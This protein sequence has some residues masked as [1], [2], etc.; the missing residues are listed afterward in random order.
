MIRRL[1]LLGEITVEVESTS[2][3]SQLGEA[4]D[5]EQLGIVRNLVGAVDG[6]ESGNRDVRQLGVV[7]KDQTTHSCEVGGCERLHGV[8]IEAEIIGDI[9]KGWKIDRAAVT[10]RHVRGSLKH[11]ERCCET[12]LEAIVCFNVQRSFD[13][14]DL[15]ANVLQRRVIVDIEARDRVQVVDTLKRTETSVCYQNARG[16]SETSGTKRQ[17]L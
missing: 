17:L 6:K 13:A 3:R 4:I 15:Q 7:N 1:H 12:R 9:G 14:G 8:A 11:G 16:F 5:L 2:N 10:E